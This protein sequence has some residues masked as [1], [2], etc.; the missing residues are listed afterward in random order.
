MRGEDE[1]AGGAA[2]GSSGGGGGMIQCF[3]TS[4]DRGK[5]KIERTGEQNQ[6]LSNDDDEEKHSKCIY[7]TSHKSRASSAPLFFPIHT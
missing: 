5:E 4:I 3:S 1:E 2:L 6:S 7:E